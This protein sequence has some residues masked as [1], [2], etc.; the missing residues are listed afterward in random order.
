MFIVDERQL[1]KRPPLEVAPLIPILNATSP[2]IKYI[3]KGKDRKAERW[4]LSDNTS[5]NRLTSNHRTCFNQVREIRRRLGPHS[6]PNRFAKEMRKCP[7]DVRESSRRLRRT[8][9]RKK[10]E[11]IGIKPDHKAL[12]PSDWKRV[13]LDLS[14]AALF[15]IFSACSQPQSLCL[16]ACGCPEKCPPYCGL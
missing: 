14:E 11:T 13:A 3:T 10:E 9:E 5:F 1:C 12:Q 6:S 4:P 16:L 2:K 8:K 15:F 7:A